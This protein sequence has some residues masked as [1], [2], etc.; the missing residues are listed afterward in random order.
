MEPAAVIVA[1]FQTPR[2]HEGHRFLVETVGA[3][4]RKLVVVLGVAP[5]KGSRRDPFD[6]FTRERML[7]AAWPSLTV[8][9]LPDH[10]S[11]AAWS[12]DLDRLLQLAFP[13]ES[14]LLY[15]SRDS[16]LPHYSGS[17]PVC[18]LP[19]QEGPS[20]TELRR[21]LAGE[22]RD[23][24]DFRCG[25]NYACQNRYLQVFPTVDVALLRRNRS[26]VLLG[27]KP[28][29]KE[30]RFPGGFADPADAS[31][32]DAARRELA[33]ECS[34]LETGALQYLGSARI[35]DWRYR[36]VPDKILTLLFATDLVYGTPR[37]ADD[38]ETLSWFPLAGL[39]A[40]A[41]AGALAHEHAPLFALL[42]GALT[43]QPDSSLQKL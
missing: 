26:E 43:Q 14:F 11:D 19:A 37:A 24:E 16:F 1:R 5:L 2:L 32:E 41:V 20:A 15:G 6:F 21:D 38:L 23:S 35:D 31:F 42:R 25:V 8:L 10:P 30:W 7:R 27:R 40:L 3:R 29:R 18:E 9:P 33:E 28:G 36:S 12:Q 4:H 13:G 39:D 22:V 17:L 34:D